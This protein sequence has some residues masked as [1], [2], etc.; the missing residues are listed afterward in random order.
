MRKRLAVVA[1][2][3]A[4]FVAAGV[5]E[6][7]WAEL[8]QG[9]G[10]YAHDFDVIEG[11]PI[12]SIDTAVSSTVSDD[13]D[14]G[15]VDIDTSNPKLD[16]RTGL[17]YVGP[18]GQIRSKSLAGGDYVVLDRPGFIVVGYDG[19]K[20][21]RITIPDNFDNDGDVV[22]VCLNEKEHANG[23]IKSI[24]VSNLEFLEVLKFRG[25]IYGDLSEL[26]VSEC[27]NLKILDIFPSALTS[28]DI[29]HN[30]KLV[31][32]FCIGGCI[33]D[34]SELERWAA[35]PGHTGVITPQSKSGIKN[36]YKA[37]FAP[38]LSF[39]IPWSDSSGTSLPFLGGMN[40][41]IG[42]SGLLTSVYVG[43]DGRF[44]ILL[45]SNKSPQSLS[46]SEWEALKGYTFTGNPGTIDWTFFGE[47]RLNW[48]VDFLSGE[49]PTIG[50]SG[51]LRGFI[52]GRIV[53]GTPV[54]TSSGARMEVS[55]IFSHEWQHY[56]PVGPVMVPLVLGFEYGVGINVAFG[57]NYN[58]ES[59]VITLDG[60]NVSILYPYLKAAGGIGFADVTN[61]SLYGSA[62][63]YVDVP[64]S[65]TSGTTGRIVGEVG[66]S[67]RIFAFTYSQPLIT[68]TYYWDTRRRVSSH[69]DEAVGL[70]DAEAVA[71]DASFELDSS[72]FDEP[73][74]WLGGS[75]SSTSV[76]AREGDATDS[77]GEVRVSAEDAN[78]SPA[79]LQTDIFGNSSPQL[80]TTDSGKCVL[81]WASV[82]PGRSVGNNVA[83]VYSVKDASTGLWSAPVIIDDDGTA[84]FDPVVAVNGETV[85]VS[86]TNVK[87]AGFSSGSD[88]SDYALE[89]ETEAV[90]L[91]VDTGAVS[92]IFH[93]DETGAC[94]TQSVSFAAD[95][96]ACVGWVENSND[97]PLEMSGSN[98]VRYASLSDGRW[99]QSAY[100]MESVPITDFAIGTLNGTLSAA[101]A[102][103][104]DDAD[105]DAD[106]IVLKVGNL[107]GAASNL[108]S[109]AAV[110]SGIR[111]VHIGGS[112]VLAWCQDGDMCISSGASSFSR[113]GSIPSADF[114]VAPIDGVDYVIYPTQLDSDDG[115]VGL[116]ARPCVD[117]VL[118]DDSLV[119][120]RAEDRYIT[121][122]SVAR[123]NGELVAAMAVTDATINVDGVTEST[124]LEVSELGYDYDLAI[125][126]AQIEFERNGLPYVPADFRVK[127]K[128][129]GLKPVGYAVVLQEEG[130]A[131]ESRH[132][133][134]TT[135]LPG[136]TVK[137]N[138]LPWLF[139]AEPESSVMNVK[140]VPVDEDGLEK[141]DG[142][143]GDNHRSVSTNCCDLLLSVQE[144]D[145]GSL[146]CSVVNW[147]NP[148]SPFRLSARKAGSDEQ[149][150]T[151]TLPSLAYGESIEVAFSS[152]DLASIGSDG[153]V[154]IFDVEP[155]EVT[156]I[157]VSDNSGSA[158]LAGVMENLAG[159]SEFDTAAAIAL[160]TFPEGAQTAILACNESYC[161]AV[162]LSGLA[163]VYNAPILLTARSDLPDA[164]LSALQEILPSGATV[165]IA[166]GTG[167]VDQ[168]VGDALTEAGFSVR[169]VFGNARDDTPVVAYGESDGWGDTAVVAWAGSFSDML[170]IAPY[171][172]RTKAPVFF[173]DGDDRIL[174]DA[175]VAAITS[176]NFDRMMLVGG[177]YVVPEA[178]MS[179][180]R[181][182][183]WSGE[184]VRLSGNDAYDTSAAVAQ[185]LVANEGF[186][187][188]GL[189]LATGTNYLDGLSGI[190]LCGSRGS[191]MMLV[192]DTEENG[193]RCIDDV[194]ASEACS[195]N[196][197]LVSVL[198]GTSVVSSY[199]RSYALAALGWL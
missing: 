71:H 185:W 54:V 78:I 58:P 50:I 11:I 74:E 129:N 190:A 99:R 63:S 153:D 40:T 145:D 39:G 158:K 101:Y 15:W 133:G 85:L 97:D 55:R 103:G 89:C 84:D 92:N 191:V 48:G 161:D 68:G 2:A 14:D 168:A 106:G 121:S 20:G 178:V 144:N 47:G 28:L 146:V 157:D 4:L 81:V 80:V 69:P 199:T 76:S 36:S 126:D 147:G 66:L 105:D 171:A 182:A 142:Y 18:F 112:D 156:D 125:E 62:S 67:A 130:T 194:L 138:F 21:D 61:V 180:L 137:E 118:A 93:S 128:N 32:L 9:Q 148:S 132:N 56:A 167:I 154:L 10:D 86:W 83:V 94:V 197:L 65:N 149:L 116:L 25:D 33:S 38:S 49:I 152:A 6:L 30:P 169:R 26:D 123:V 127:I 113:M 43:E 193:L 139:R 3:I 187:Y 16:E 98:T 52:E 122:Y 107:T 87:T 73:S 143:L 44:K 42:L 41:T 72:L 31:Y 23:S 163:G 195:S 111:F 192:S 7:A 22:A 34:L 91:D 102:L 45:G 196:T 17:L 189:A 160:S 110:V 35:I 188:H 141:S 100:R 57:V 173:T 151:R 198:G 186:S 109:K 181:A 134:R 8:P 75:V 96:T 166:G 162:A 159:T 114:R 108:A 183:G 19:S 82:V 172:Y 174:N 70:S 51:T 37:A 90:L 175:A 164:T 176:G 29:S 184:N 115:T 24:D 155:I 46:D 120:A 1:M 27:P 12:D 124:S 177:S 150:Y 79:V 77:S 119:L 131:R 88:L 104:A 95:G 59:G 5:P 170:S 179:Q 64:A 135:I 60:S 117:G 136:Q 140:V 165:I 53:N 13:S